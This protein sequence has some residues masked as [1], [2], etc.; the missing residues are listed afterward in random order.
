MKP[1]RVTH[2]GGVTFAADVRGHKVVTDQPAHAGGDNAGPMPVELMG[3]AL[4]S[5]VALYVQQFCKA[6]GIDH[7]GM[8]VDVETA[9]ARDP[10][11]VGLFDLKITLP[12]ALPERYAEAIDRVARSCAVYNTFMVAPEVRVSLQVAE[13]EE[14]A[15]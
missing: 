1:I 5:C 9:G 6:R 11:R 2:E 14:A 12:E 4:G 13:S 7:Q 15:A 10:N 3:V 8:A